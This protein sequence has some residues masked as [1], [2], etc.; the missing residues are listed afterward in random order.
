LPGSR[1]ERLRDHVVGMSDK[2][3][4]KNDQ[5]SIMHLLV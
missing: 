2:E 5:A 1:K 3:W 4:L